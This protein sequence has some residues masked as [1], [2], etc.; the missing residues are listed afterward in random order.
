MEFNEEL[1]NRGNLKISG[2][3]NSE[4]GDYNEVHISGAGNINGNL[5]CID[6]HVSGSSNVN[7]D[8]EAENIKIS[9]SAKIQGNIMAK[10]ISASGSAKIQGKIKTDKISA[11]GVFKA[12]DKVEAR[13]IKSSGVCEFNSDV[14]CEKIHTSGSININGNCESELF[15]SSGMFKIGGLLNSEVIDIDLGGRCETSE[16]GGN[17]INIYCNKNNFGIFNIFGHFNEG[18]LFCKVIEGDEIE[19]SNVTADLVRGRNIIVNENCD[20]KKIEY[21]DNFEN[22]GNSK[23]GETIKNN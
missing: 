20:I 5:R 11:S 14:K 18:R 17:K 16:I 15:E 6:M 7:G 9:G 3:S 12:F 10:E 1:R 23:I 13:K 4:G 21:D 22:K 8:V 19:L 2:A